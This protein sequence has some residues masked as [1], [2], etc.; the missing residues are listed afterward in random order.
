[1]T[2]PAYAGSGQ[3]YEPY[4]TAVSNTYTRLYYN[5]L[6]V[7]TTKAELKRGAFSPGLSPSSSTAASRRAGEDSGSA[8]LVAAIVVLLAGLLLAAAATRR[9]ALSLVR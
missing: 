4:P 2:V 6:G 7:S 5:L 1:M 8:G 3:L 9:R